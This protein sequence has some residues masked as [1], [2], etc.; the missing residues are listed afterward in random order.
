M[1]SSCMAVS[2]WVSTLS[3][4]QRKT[5][6]SVLSFYTRLHFSPATSQESS[7]SKCRDPWSLQLLVEIELHNVWTVTSSVV[8]SRRSSSRL[9]PASWAASADPTM[10]HSLVS[11]LVCHSS[12]GSGY[13]PKYQL[14][15]FLVSLVFFSFEKLNSHSSKQW[16][17]PAWADLLF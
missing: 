7:K 3:R 13:S 8:P 17:N 15:L 5:L 10:T 12:L 14:S 11:E 1:F 4:L 9:L 2:D 16:V 6:F